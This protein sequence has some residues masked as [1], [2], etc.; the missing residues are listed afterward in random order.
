MRA[1]DWTDYRA[2]HLFGIGTQV[3]NACCP[4][5]GRNGDRPVRQK[6]GTD[7]NLPE[8]GRCKVQRSDKME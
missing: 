1:V 5:H 8:A 6:Y 7:F 3:F 2:D 4:D